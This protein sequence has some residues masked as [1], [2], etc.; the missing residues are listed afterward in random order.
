MGTSSEWCETRRCCGQPIHKRYTSDARPITSAFA[1]GRRAGYRAVMSILQRLF[2]R[3]SDPREAARPLY[4]AV[5]AHGRTPQWYL[6]GVP[7]TMD[8]RFEIIAAVLSLVLLRLESAESA[9]LRSVQ[10]TEIFVDDMDGQL[11]QIGIGDLIV[12]KHIGKMM[13]ALGGRLTA[14]RA[15]GQDA[16]VLRDVV[17][18]NLWNNDDPGAAADAVAARLARFAAA[19]EQAPLAAIM[20][21]QLPPLPA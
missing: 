17:V 6:D 3:R 12:G 9:R 7:D 2:S 13:A 8:G 11:R 15:A 14:Y 5:V 10:L 16:A 20:D 21:G 1:S 18:R 4:Q 19:L